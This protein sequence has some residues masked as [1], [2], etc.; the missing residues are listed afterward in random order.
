VIPETF[1]TSIGL[2]PSSISM[3]SAV[4]CTHCQV[5]MTS[6][7]VAGSPIRYYQCPF[8]ARTHSSQYDEVFRARAGARRVEAPA[9]RAQPQALPMASPDEQRWAGIKARAA[10]WFT[11]LEASEQP[12]PAARPVGAVQP[13][14]VRAGVAMPIARVAVRP[15]RQR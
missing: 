6:W 9:H 5:T 13:G 12:P 8:C 10:R 3:D 11:R 14:G 15:A 7:S 2:V 4:E 1:L